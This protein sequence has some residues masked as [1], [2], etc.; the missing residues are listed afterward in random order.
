MTLKIKLGK[1]RE[2]R[3]MKHLKVEHPS[4]RGNISLTNSKKIKTNKI[5]LMN[6]RSN[7]ELLLGHALMHL[8]WNNPSRTNWTK[9]Q[10]R[11][12]HSR[13]VKIMLKRG[14]NHN[15]PLR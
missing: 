3:L 2:K 13:L 10:I 9:T 15:S 7:K 12:E 8:W 14:F 6:T 1:K 4:V 5:N 11:K